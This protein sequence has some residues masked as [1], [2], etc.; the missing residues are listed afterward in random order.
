MT[1]YAMKKS[2]K[3]ARL[4]IFTIQ[5]EMA[6]QVAGDRRVTLAGDKKYDTHDFVLTLRESGVTPMLLPTSSTR[7]VPRSKEEQPVT[8]AMW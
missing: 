5:A 4:N 6:E 2:G 7:A 1:S 8:Q 3:T